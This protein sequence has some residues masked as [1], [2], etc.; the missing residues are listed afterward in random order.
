MAIICS[1]SNLHLLLVYRLSGIRAHFVIAGLMVQDYSSLNFSC[2]LKQFELHLLLVYHAVALREEPRICF[3][4]LMESLVKYPGVEFKLA[5]K[6]KSIVKSKLS[7]C[8]TF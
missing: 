5:K 1:S 4:C 6:L 8:A 7:E 2:L 3:A